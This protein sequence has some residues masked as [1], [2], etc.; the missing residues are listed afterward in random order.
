VSW[1]STGWTNNRN[2]TQLLEIL[3]VCGDV[4]IA[5]RRGAQRVWDLADP[6]R[7]VVFA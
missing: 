3:N 1:P 5:G 7:R 2:V 6:A 4:A